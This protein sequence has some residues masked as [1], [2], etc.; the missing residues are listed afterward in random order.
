MRQTRMYTSHYGTADT[1]SRAVAVTKLLRKLLVPGI[2][3]AL[4]SCGGS[5]NPVTAPPNPLA[6]VIGTYVLTAVNDSSVLRD[7]PQS[8]FGHY[9]LLAGTLV[10]RDNYTFTGRETLMATYVIPGAPLQFAKDL[11]FGGG[12]YTVSGSSI[13]LR[14]FDGGGATLAWTGGVAGDVV[15]LKDPDGTVYTFQKL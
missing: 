5:S 8:D 7:F 10:L 6:T 2:I 11:T 15:T 1:T 9:R 13:T 3:A 14:S 4:S 12:T